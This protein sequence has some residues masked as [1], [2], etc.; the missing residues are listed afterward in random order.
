MYGSLLD[1]YKICNSLNQNDV[2]T[3]RVPGMK[4]CAQE[5]FALMSVELYVSDGRTYIIIIIYINI[6]NSR[7]ALPFMWGSLRLAPINIIIYGLRAFVS[8][9]WGSLRLAP[10]MVVD[11]VYTDTET[12]AHYTN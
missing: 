11:I 8:S 6:Y 2:H 4:I 3:A 7:T 12:H 1:Q 5:Y 10:I 9:M